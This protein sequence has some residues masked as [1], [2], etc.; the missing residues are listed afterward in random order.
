VKVLA[1]PAVAGAVIT[2]GTATLEETA[3]MMDLLVDSP[4]PIVVTGAQRNFDEKDADGPRN[5]LYAIMVAADPASAGRGVMVSVGGE[6]HAARD[7]IKV[8]T[9]RLTAFTS[10]DSGKIGEVS[11][12]GV[13]YFNRP[14]RR[15]LKTSNR[16]RRFGQ[17]QALSHVC[18]LALIVFSRSLPLVG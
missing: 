11:Q 17:R 9:Y 15:L 1:D 12:D 5:I 8:H 2:H 13:I 14:G 3:Y 10:R 4:K 7:A 18:P 6:I 16:T